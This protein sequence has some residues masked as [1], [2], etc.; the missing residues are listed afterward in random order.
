MF[1]SSILI[2]II[3]AGCVLKHTF[4]RSVQSHT[5]VREFEYNNG[6]RVDRHPRL[7]GDVNGDG[8]L[9]IVGFAYA[10]TYVSLSH[11]N[12]TFSKA[13]LFLNEFGY[14]AGAWRVNRHPRLLGDVNGDGRADIV[15]FSDIGPYVALGQSNG[16]FST[17]RLVLSEFGYSAGGWRVEKHPRMLADV[18]GDGR[19]D[20][21]GF[22]D[23]GSFLALAQSDGTFSTPRLVLSK[24]GFVAGCWRMDKNPRLLG[25]VNGDGKSDIVGF[26]D[27]GT[28]V[29]LGQSNGTFSAPQ[30]VLKSFGYG[31]GSWR[32]EK[33]P[34]LLGDVNGDGNADIVAFS[35]KGPYV[36]LGRSNGT[37]STPRLVLRTFGYAAGGWRVD[38]HP[39]LLGD[40]NGDGKMDIVAF[41]DAGTQVGL[42]QSDGSF[43]IPHLVLRKF[44]YGA[45]GWRVDRHPRVLGDVNG[46]GKVD[47][48]GFGY[49]GPFLALGKSDGTFSTPRLLFSTDN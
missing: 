35:D 25:D 3:L 21:V 32:V 45:G 34:R 26:A 48:V 20:I 16:T 22:G 40:V 8:Y 44:G 10:G 38:K 36:A 28:Y 31:A 37:F 39:R 15:A 29:S 7:L 49:A 9:D 23:A 33:N 30:L 13:R 43:S 6:W 4:A 12:G 1:F 24:Y 14:S 19:D 42:G 2:F 27:D 5:E 41:G 47:I 11:G 46:D 18:N 17:P